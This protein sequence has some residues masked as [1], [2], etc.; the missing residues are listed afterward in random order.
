LAAAALEVIGEVGLGAL[1]MR[2]LADH[3]GVKAAS[4]YW[5]VRDRDELIALV[6]QALMDQVHVGDRKGTWRVA[7]LAVC[8]ALCSVVDGRPDAARVLLT[9]PEIVNRSATHTR[10]QEL[11]LK[12]GLMQSEAAATAM[13]MLSHVLVWSTGPE[14][15]PVGQTD[16]ILTVAVD[17]GS[18][19]VT[20]QAGG[21]MQELLRATTDPGTSAPAI[22]HGDILKVRRL[23][24]GRQGK[25]DLNPAHP[26]RIKVQG[27]TWN[28]RLELG[29]L[30]VREIQL[31][32]GA[33]RVDCVLPDPRGVVP[34]N[35]SGGAVAVRIHRPPGAAVVVDASAGAAQL[36]LDAMSIAATTSDLHWESET[37]AAD[38][39]HYLVHISGGALRVTLTDDAQPAAQ[40]LAGPGPVS[41]AGTIELALNVALDGAER[42]TWGARPRTF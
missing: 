22:E 6:A 42:R 32:G 25:L 31:D 23:R 41:T 38:G 16:R 8:N 34:I 26:W 2:A 24:G 19:G 28:T 36:Q 15:A 14:L 3:L 20:L 29:G 30:D 13:M 39:D 11:L 35:V 1:S 9:V 5:H 10:L 33:T 7:A 4:L 18:R 21:P 37:A 12:A 17:S 40:G 27:P